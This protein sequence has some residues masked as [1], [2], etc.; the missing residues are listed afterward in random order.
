MSSNPF[1]ESKPE[2]EGSQTIRQIPAWAV[3]FAVVLM[4]V[5]FNLFTGD[6]EAVGEGRQKVVVHQLDEVATLNDGTT[7]AIDDVREELGMLGARF[8]EVTITYVAGENGHHPTMEQPVL[9]PSGGESVLP[10]QGAFATTTKGLADV[11]APN[12]VQT[13][14]IGYE[15]PITD[16]TQ[17]QLA[18]DGELFAGD[19]TKRI[20]IIP[21]SE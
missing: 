11:L 2:Q 10:H 16:L 9:T 4:I 3:V 5:L 14:T 20:G 13:L 15:V 7:I 8:T 19:F 6:D 18:I 1:G 12:M 17:A 21:P